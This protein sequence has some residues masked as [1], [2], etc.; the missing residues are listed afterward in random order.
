MEKRLV[1][2]CVLTAAIL[3]G[4]LLVQ[5]WLFPKPPP[6][7]PTT[8]V[9]AD[10]AGAD[11]S[12]GKSDDSTAK[13]DEPG[14]TTAEKPEAG[15]DDGATKPGEPPADG[16]TAASKPAV[17][18]P[19][20]V[21]LGSLDPAS[22]YRLLVTLSNQGAAIERVEVSSPQYRDLEDKSGYW[23]ELQPVTKAGGGARLR[24]VGRGTPA[25][26]AQPAVASDG[27]GLR[28]GDVVTQ[29]DER[30]IA[31]AAQLAEQLAASRP[32][33]TWKV[34][35]D[36]DGSDR[37]YEVRLDRRP[38]AVLRRDMQAES[39]PIGGN[40]PSCLFRL[41]SVGNERR[42]ASMDVK[43]REIA[44]LP[45]LAEGFWEVVRQTE[46][47]VEFRMRLDAST[48]AKIKQ[49]GDLEILRRYRLKAVAP[50]LRD[51]PSQPAYHVEM[52]VEL[53]TSSAKGL[54]VAGHLS[55]P[56]GL[57][58]EGWWYTTKISGNWS[59]SGA[60]D[61]VVRTDGGGHRLFSCQNVFSQAS[62]AEK[63]QLALFSDNEDD[64]DRTLRYLGVD[65]QYFAAMLLPKGEGDQPPRFRNAS[66]VAVGDVTRVEQGRNRT[67]NVSF[68]LTTDARTVTPDKPWLQQYVLFAGPKHADLLYG[69]GEKTEGGHFDLGSLLEY[70][71]F[72]WVARPMSRILHWI[73]AVVGNYGIAV[74]LLT[75]L[76]R[77]CMLPISHKAAK[78]TQKMQLLAPEMKKIAE[79]YKNDMEKR[80]RAQQELY[81]KYD[82]NPFSGC[83]LALCQLPIFIGLYRSLSVDIE[84]RQARI[85][86]RWDWCSNLSGPDMFWYWKPFVPAFLSDETGYLGPY[87]NLLPLL[88]IALFL[89]NQKMLT[90]PPTDE[91]TRL[92]HKIM[93]M[94]TVFIGVMFFKVPAGLCIY[95][96]ASSIWSLTE[97]KV[98]RRQ[99]AQ[100]ADASP[101]PAPPAKPAGGGERKPK[102]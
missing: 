20:W 80:G 40:P 94:M 66:A 59:G 7:E 21:S 102:R 35:V 23:G 19:Q 27:V 88:T 42:R 16:S 10:G 55:G 47:E 86:S 46:D 6:S 73:Y 17:V 12:T 18:A 62:D 15:A 24:V 48:L 38:L 90:P 96:I 91:Q 78:N 68:E 31:D 5:A 74:I 29:I 8:V 84:L 14:G 11:D 92:Q 13:T 93:M 2:F 72:G 61:I 1:L 32:G 39:D 95:F 26:G 64:D 99:P 25:A 65:A 56:N 22:G 71:W 97:H 41:A 98:L 100:P 60:R 79:L 28:A 101:P 85:F 58:L 52:D 9:D 76:V 49:T 54:S 34:V 51:D 57:P 83:L 77:S 44:G 75:V 69:Y 50:E 67:L 70:G 30:P 53:R 36:R 4:H 43:S 82:I 45:S 37:V 33:Q 89:F 81:R 87:F 63:P 3:G